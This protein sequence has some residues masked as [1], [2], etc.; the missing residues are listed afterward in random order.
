MDYTKIY[1]KY[2]GK[3]I[4]LDK[5]LKKVVAYDKDVN[6]TFKKALEGGIEKPTL[7]KV[8]KKNLPYV[9]FANEL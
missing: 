2:S 5:T 3:W 1:K 9:G 6:K 4:A 7:F 8:P